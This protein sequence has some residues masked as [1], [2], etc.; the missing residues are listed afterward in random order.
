MSSNQEETTVAKNASGRPNEPRVSVK[1]PLIFA[2][3]LGVIAGFFTMIFST[4]GAS[5]ALRWDLG[6]TAAGIAFIASLLVVA[7]LTMSTKE[8]PNHLSEGSGI[9]RVSSKIPGGA[10]SVKPGA[11][12]PPEPDAGPRDGEPDDGA[13]PRR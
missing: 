7:V 11:P 13:S 12:V 10:G 9:H 4:G 3:V 1:A 8:N 5:K 2:A 6:L